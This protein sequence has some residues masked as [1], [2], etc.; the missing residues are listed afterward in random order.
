MVRQRIERGGERLWRL[1]DFRDLPFTAVAQALSRLTRKGM[2]ER[3]SKGVYYRTRD[4]PF[5]KSRR[6]RAFTRPSLNDYEAV[7]RSSLSRPPPVAA[8]TVPLRT[9][10]RAKLAGRCIRLW[11]RRSRP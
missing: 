3:L 2:I 7:A 1:Q 10:C 8:P 4:T 5:G 6:M 9:S 11:V